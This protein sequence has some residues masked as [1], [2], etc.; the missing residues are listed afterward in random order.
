MRFG[1]KVDI[2]SNMVFILT[3]E[4]R[5]DKSETSVFVQKIKKSNLIYMLTR[6]EN[7]NMHTI[8]VHACIVQFLVE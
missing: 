6:A 5:S 3:P 8:L 1:E 4:I 7:E 2:N